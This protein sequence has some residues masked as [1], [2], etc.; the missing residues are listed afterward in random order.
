[1]LL[2]GIEG[3]HGLRIAPHLL[4]ERLHIFIQGLAKLFGK[5]GNFL[6]ARTIF[7]RLAQRFLSIPKCP[8]RHGE[9]AILDRQCEIPEQWQQ[10]PQLV[11]GVGA[12]E[13]LVGKAHSQIVLCRDVEAFRGEKKGVEGCDDPAVIVGVKCQITALLDHCSCQ[14]LSKRPLWQLE[15]MWG[16]QAL[17]SGLIPCNQLKCDL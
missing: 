13:L 8:F 6:F 5:L 1:M 16:R 12:H 7:Q 4:C 9:V 15:D 17:L 3:L 14:R 11:I 2:L 10:L